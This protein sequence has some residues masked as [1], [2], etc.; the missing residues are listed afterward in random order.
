MKIRKQLWLWLLLPVQL[1]TAQNPVHLSDCQQWAREQHPLL[2][3][4]ELYRQMSALKLVNNQTNYLPQV[5][6]KAQAVY[7]SDVTHLPV[8][9]PGM[10]ISSVSK[11]QYKAYLDVRQNP[12]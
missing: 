5:E 1:A 12:C 4:N 2:R 10:A 8:E 11:D 9:L 3:Q 6:L 7:L